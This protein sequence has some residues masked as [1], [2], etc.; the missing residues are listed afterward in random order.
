MV[1]RR[2]WCCGWWW[3]KWAVLR[4]GLGGCFCAAQK[5]ALAPSAPRR[6]CSRLR[7]EKDLVRRGIPRGWKIARMR[8]LET[9]DSA[10]PSAIG[11]TATPCVGGG[12]GA[13][14][15]L[16]LVLVPAL[17]GWRRWWRRRWWWWGR[18]RRW[19]RRWCAGAGAGCGSGCGAGG[20]GGGGGGGGAGTGAGTGALSGAG[21]ARVV[22]WWPFSLSLLSLPSLSP[23]SLPPLFPSLSPSL[24]SS[25][26]LSLLPSAL[27]PS[28]QG[29]HPNACASHAA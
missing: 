1:V 17:V 24:S 7:C 14:L 15:V 9:R 8:G 16:V 28:P 25:L 3:W 19:S 6:C 4:S 27:A 20:G 5:R 21:G 2:R 26:Y 18:R 22:G 23:F 13:V 12:W 11:V 29:E 10:I